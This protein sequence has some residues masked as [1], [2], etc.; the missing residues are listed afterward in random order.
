MNNSNAF[1]DRIVLITGA[2]RGIGYAAAKAFAAQG[3]HVIAVARTVGGLEELDDEIKA[4]GGTA[5]LIPVDLT[6]YAALDRLPGIL[7]ERYGRLDALILNAGVLGELTPVQDMSAALWDQ[8]MAINVT[9]N[10]RLLA[11][12]DPLLRAAPAGRIVGLSSSRARKFAPF[13]GMYSATKAAFEALLSVYAMENEGSSLH[14][15]IIDPGP[16]RTG[17]RAKAMPGEDPLTLATPEDLAPLIL[18]LASAQETR[19]GAIV[20]FKEWR[21]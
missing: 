21:S 2:S 8:A 14:C 13:W 5:S 4:V 19:Q 15:N 6:D 16:I 17:M 7:A 9:A 12:L 3:A 10:A 20:S 11:G 18:E 1:S